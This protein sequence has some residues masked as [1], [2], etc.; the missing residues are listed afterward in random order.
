MKSF[1]FKFRV[2]YT[3]INKILERGQYKNIR[4]F[5]D[6]LSIA[7]GLYNKSVILME[8][9]RYFSTKEMPT[10][11]LNEAKDFYNQLYSRYKQFNPKFIT[12]FDNGTCLQNSTLSKSYKEGRTIE[13][14]FTSDLELDLFIRI[15]RYY[16]DTIYSHFNKHPLSYVINLQEYEADLVPYFVI[17]RNILNS[18]K[19]D[20]LNVI[21]S[22]DKD[23]LQCCKF[24]NTIQCITTYSSKQGKLLFNVYHNNN[25]VSYFYK[26]FKEGLGITAKYVPL[27]LALAGDKADGIP[28]IK[29]VGYARAYQLILKHK[30][31]YTITKTTELPNELNSYRNLI[32]KNLQLID[33]QHQIER[34]PNMVISK[35][36]NQFQG[37]T[38]E[39]SL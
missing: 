25:A 35:M 15:K 10:T 14:Y 17:N 22:T 11:M 28:G 29:G 33:F 18:Q 30:L 9:D 27:I 37:E 8:L 24:T 4:F 21:L 6:I 16:L 39:L 20:T 13:D 5:I 12:F 3:T 19:F 2:P 34:L 26:K 7:R 1:Y 23:L 38:G 36:I 31:P 32:I